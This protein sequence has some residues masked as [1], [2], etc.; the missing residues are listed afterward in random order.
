MQADPSSSRRPPLS[1]KREI[2][3]E[4]CQE[5]AAEGYLWAIID[6][7]DVLAVAEKLRSLGQDKARSLLNDDYWAVTPYL[8]S[9]DS[10]MLLWLQKH[11][12]ATPWGIF[13]MAKRPIDELFAHFVKLLVSRLPDGEDWFFRYYDPRVLARFLDTCN[14]QELKAFYGPVRGYA[15]GN[16]DTGQ[17]TAFIPRFGS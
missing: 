9:L 5:L 16:R 1:Q 4:Q 10:E 11:L 14:A 3:F 15:I 2:S 17:C 8:V 7:C 13:V 6:A 12:W